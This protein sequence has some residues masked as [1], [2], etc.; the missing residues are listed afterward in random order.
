MSDQIFFSP[1]LKQSV[2]ISN[3][4]D[5]YELSQSPKRLDTKDLKKFGNIRKISKFH[6]N[7]VFLTK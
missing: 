4:Y 6:I 2:I 1:Q 7:I 3:K 5:I